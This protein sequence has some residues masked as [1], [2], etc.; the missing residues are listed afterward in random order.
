MSPLLCRHARACDPARGVPPASWIP[1]PAE[2]VVRDKPRLA[3]CLRPIQEQ[4]WLLVF[5]HDS[6]RLVRCRNLISRRGT[7]WTSSSLSSQLR[8]V[9]R[10]W[11][12]RTLGSSRLT[13]SCGARRQLQIPGSAPG[14]QGGTL[15]FS[16]LQYVY[17]SK[18]L[19]CSVPYTLRRNCKAF[20]ML[21]H[22]CRVINA[23]HEH[24]D[25]SCGDF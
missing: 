21:N 15:G 16:R 20:N 23:V 17:P 9:W 1:D 10:S 25:T 7:P 22:C 4:A 19:F 24:A 2:G 14:V 13:N 11:L 8:W 18:D 12:P 6:F 3:P 5:V